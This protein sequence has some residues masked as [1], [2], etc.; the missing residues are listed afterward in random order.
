M[1]LLPEIIK[2][3]NVHVL[4]VTCKS[5]VADQNRYVR[6]TVA[7]RSLCNHKPEIFSESLLQLS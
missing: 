1:Y 6:V 5:P 3:P 7:S 2:Q 4:Y